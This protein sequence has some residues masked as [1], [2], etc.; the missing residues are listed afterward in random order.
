MLRGVTYQDRQNEVGE[1]PGEQLVMS[2]RRQPRE[3]LELR[4]DLAAAEL[5]AEDV[6]Q[7][8][9]GF[10]QARVAARLPCGRRPRLP[11]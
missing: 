6:D 10:D 9:M 8:S 2:E 1:T 7:L 5:Q 4:V 3:R 11:A